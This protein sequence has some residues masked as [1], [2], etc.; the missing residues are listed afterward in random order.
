MI[1]LVI[2]NVYL[3][4]FEK[5]IW[6]FVEKMF[7]FLEFLGDIFVILIFF[8]LNFLKVLV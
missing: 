8:G 6:L 3:G 5:I 2:L 4:I 7:L 1:L